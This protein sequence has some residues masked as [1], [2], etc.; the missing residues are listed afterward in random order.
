MVEP[1]VDEQLRDCYAPERGHLCA[2]ACKHCGKIHVQYELM[3]TATG[4]GRRDETGDL[5]E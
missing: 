2:Q 3:M 4:T 1:G 5:G